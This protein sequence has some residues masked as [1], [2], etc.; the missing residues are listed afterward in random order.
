MAEIKI[1]AGP[2][3]WIEGDAIQQL[4]KTAQRPG[5]L[6]GIGM[7]DL[8]P[9][10][11]C[12]VGA[13]FVTE[14]IIYPDL[15]GGD[16]GCGMALWR[17]TIRQRQPERL[18]KKLT[19]LE[20]GVSDAE[21]CCE[22]YGIRP[23]GFEHNLGTIGR[24]NHFAELLVLD[25]L[26]DEFAAEVLGDSNAL[27]LVHS[28]SRGYGEKILYEHTAVYRDQGISAEDVETWNA[29]WQHHNHALDWAWLNRRIV[30]E[31]ILDR[32]G[33]QGELL[34]DIPHNFVEP[35]TELTSPPPRFIHRKGA[36]PVRLGQP[37]IIPGSRGAHSYLVLPEVRNHGETGWSL[38]HGAGR[39]M[40]RMDARRRHNRGIREGLGMDAVDKLKRT[41]LGSVVIC[42]DRLLLKEEIPEAYKP[43]D[44]VIQDL[45]DHRLI[46]VLALLKPLV[47]YKT[48]RMDT[49]E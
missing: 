38:S 17:T 21:Q 15:I 47:T 40:S 48:R 11:S 10:K 3:S 32:L 28:G 37:V 22:R 18:A 1:I 6:R 16:V 13:V 26:R 2:K 42:D 30:A 14:D 20:G 46:K 45:V 43:I 5:M 35:D 24:G 29:Y 8:H 9:G 41:K 44:R 31:R 25:E 27:L 39:K 7:P 33:A 4:E 36:I 23:C 19:G 12:P 49:N 34:F